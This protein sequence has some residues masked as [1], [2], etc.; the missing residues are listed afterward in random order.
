M[1]KLG[2]EDSNPR[3]AAPKAAALPLGDAPS[4]DDNLLLHIVLYHIQRISAT[5]SVW[6]AQQIAGSWGASSAT[7]HPFDSFSS[8]VSQ[9]GQQ[10]EIYLVKGLLGEFVQHLDDAD[11]L[12]LTQ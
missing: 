8:D 7:F 6:L 4:K 10:V 1:S 3:I 5:R 9:D 11:D 2:R 12:V